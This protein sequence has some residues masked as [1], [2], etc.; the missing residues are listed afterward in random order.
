[1]AY[2][3]PHKRRANSKRPT[4][5]PDLLVPQLKKTLNLSESSSTSNFER[6]GKPTLHTCYGERTYANQAIHKWCAAGLRNDNYLPPP[7]SLKP[8]SYEFIEHKKGIMPQ[9]LV[10][11]HIAK[12]NNEARGSVLDI[13]C[14]SIVKDLLS[15]YENVKNEMDYR[16]LERVKPMLVARFGK[17]LFHEGSLVSLEKGCSAASL[18]QM[19]KSFYT[20]VTELYT[21]RIINEVVPQIGLHFDEENE[22]YHIKLSDEW[23]PGATIRCKCRVMED[24]K[25]LQLLKVE[26]HHL[27]HLVVDISCLEK[28]FDFRL[29]LYTRRILMELSENEMDSI[30]DLVTCAILDP[31]VKCGLRWKDSPGDRYKVVGVWHTRAKSYKSSSM[32]LAIRDAER[33][34]FR[35]STEEVTREVTLK[36]RGLVS[37]LQDPKVEINSFTDMFKDALKLIWDHFLGGDGFLT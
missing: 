35:T 15:A 34:D 2:I 10:N 1:M 4:P 12:D 7:V 21:N 13:P 24:D 28:N 3:P 6:K 17:V 9:A 18:E 32:E 14:T 19:K 26:L 20:N 33:Y 22:F 25:K 16:Q 36:M 23:R 8:I 11:T 5:A 37:Q 27:R 30:R 31:N 29:M